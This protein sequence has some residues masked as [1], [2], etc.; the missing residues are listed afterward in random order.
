MKYS[1]SASIITKHVRQ[2]KQGGRK[3]EKYN[4][5]PEARKIEIGWAHPRALAARKRRWSNGD[6]GWI[7]TKI[8]S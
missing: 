3:I 6:C 2:S 1:T 8:F 5:M 4:R 7:N